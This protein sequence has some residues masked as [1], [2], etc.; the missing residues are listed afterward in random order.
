MSHEAWKAASRNGLIRNDPTAYHWRPNTHTSISRL[1][2][3][4]SVH[5]ILFYIETA[6][7]NKRERPGRA[8][9]RARGSIGVDAQPLEL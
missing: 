8:F 1:I 4:L 2:R 7:S 6:R 5:L 9:D 3:R